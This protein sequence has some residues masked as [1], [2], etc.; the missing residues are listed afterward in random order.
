MTNL[1]IPPQTREAW[2]QAAVEKLRPLFA[3]KG[4]QIPPVQ[5][6]IGF[7]NGGPRCHHIGQCWPSHMAEDKISHIF[8][9]PGLGNPVEILDVLVHELVHAVDNCASSHGKVFK[10]IALS[11]GLEGHM[12]SAHAGAKLKAQLGELAQDL[13]PLQHGALAKRP[14]RAI[15]AKRPRARCKECGYEVPMLKRFL[16]YGPPLCPQ[17]KTIMEEIGDW[18]FD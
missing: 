1:V 9:V 16:E 3:A 13:G 15:N 6:S 5:V 14:K 8:I 18:E 2:L 11:V 4:H 12:R 10:K 17:H 7:T